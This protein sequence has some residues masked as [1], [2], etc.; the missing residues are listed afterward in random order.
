MDLRRLRSGEVVVAASGLVLLVSLFLPWYSITRF[1]TADANAWQALGVIDVLLFVLAL[2]ALAVVPATAGPRTPSLAIAYQA[3]L[4]LGAI[5]GSIL[6]LFRLLST[7]EDGLSR[8]IGCYVG[9]L[10][11]LGVLSGCLAALRDERASSPGQLTDS[12]GVPVQSPAPVE[13]VPVPRP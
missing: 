2:G 1:P 5:A 9:T 7:P 10:A 3:L 13:S 11:S 6:A 8:E 4:C 12:T